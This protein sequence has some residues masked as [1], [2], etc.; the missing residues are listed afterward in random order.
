MKKKQVFE[1]VQVIGPKSKIVDIFNTV[2]NNIGS[3]IYMKKE[4]E[5]DKIEEIIQ[6]LNDRNVKSKHLLYKRNQGLLNNMVISEGEVEFDSVREIFLDLYELN[7]FVS[8]EHSTESTRELW[9]KIFHCYPNVSWL[10]ILQYENG[11]GNKSIREVHINDVLSKKSISS[12]FEPTQIENIR[13]KHPQYYKS[14]KYLEISFQL[15]E[16]E[17]Q[18][19]YLLYKKKLMEENL[20]TQEIFRNLWNQIL[21]EIPKQEKKIRELEETLDNIKNRKDLSYLKECPTTGN[22]S[23]RMIG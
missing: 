14:V 15:E 3:P 20:E 12:H 21:T 22:H 10:V 8:Y 5:L 19:E 6:H 23:K 2:L 7:M 18:L 16:E 9:S 11:M 17:G 4:E 1:M 13:K